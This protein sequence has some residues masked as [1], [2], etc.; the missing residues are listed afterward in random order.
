MSQAVAARFGKYAAREVRVGDCVF[1]V[2]AYDKKLKMFHVVECKK[3]SRVGRIGQTFGQIA[4]YH[5]T[6]AAYGKAFGIAYN[7]K[8]P[9]FHLGKWMEATNDNRHVTVAFY[10]ALTKS[11]CMR[12]ELLC[13]LKKLIP[14]VGIIRVNPDGYCRS[15]IRVSGK[16]ETQLMKA[17]PI[18]IKILRG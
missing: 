18:R 11:A 5:A 14:H 16:R 6:L 9:G 17:H 12:F 1:D 3:S 2:V 7:R 15:H 10:V 4:A 13:A 8:V